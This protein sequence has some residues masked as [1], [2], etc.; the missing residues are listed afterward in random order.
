VET[1][2][3]IIWWIESSKEQHFCNILD[4]F[5]ITLDQFNASLLNKS[6]HFLKNKTYQSV[7][8]FLSVKQKNKNKKKIF[9]EDKIHLNILSEL[10]IAVSFGHLFYNPHIKDNITLLLPCTHKL[11]SGLLSIIHKQPILP[12]GMLKIA[13]HTLTWELSGL[14]KPKHPLWPFFDK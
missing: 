12:L 7:L 9:I 14:I 4:V 5:T 2:F 8:N 3:S 6:I 10:D 13:R 1:F 11:L